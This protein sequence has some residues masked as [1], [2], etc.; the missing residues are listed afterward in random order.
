ME[1]FKTPG[2]VKINDTTNKKKLPQM[3]RLHIN[4]TSTKQGVSAALLKEYAVIASKYDHKYDRKAAPA[5]LAC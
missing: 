2:T 4:Y 5:A 1:L 3:P